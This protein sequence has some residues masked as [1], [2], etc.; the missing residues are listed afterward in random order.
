VRSVQRDLPFDALLLAG[1]TA[2][3][4]SAWALRLAREWPIEIV[5][6]DA[7]QV[8]RGFDVGSAKPAAAVRAAVPHHLLDLRD[9]WEQYT[10]GD[11][12]RDA[13]AA[14]ADIRSRGRLPVLVGGTMMYFRA[15]LH[16]LVELPPIEPALRVA[17]R[18]RA[19][20]QGWPAL[21]AELQRVDPTAAA[22]IEPS[23]AQRIERALEVYRATG[24]P[25]SAWQAATGP[26]HGLRLEG[27]ALVPAE[28]ERLH[29]RIAQR[30]AAMMESGFLAEV[31][32]LAAA[33]PGAASLRAVGYRQLLA[34]V[35]GRM[36]LA[37]AMKRA[38]AATR[39]LAKRQLTW[40][41]AEPS[42]RRCDPFAEL[43]LEK[44][45]EALM[46]TG[47]HNGPVTR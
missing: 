16:G 42:W 17:I 37:E 15:L 7:T 27:W 38:L 25:I 4:K 18:A 19:A 22:R 8:Y 41:N 36:T 32:A 3:G 12:V 2:S 14:I 45:L 46:S 44:W 6:V 28:R 30:F 5:S 11:F 1:P 31:A 21:H 35:E 34:H 43:A 29:E 39:Q 33:A 20:E 10:A 23:D 9:P 24:R 40:I 13:L 26:R 47:G